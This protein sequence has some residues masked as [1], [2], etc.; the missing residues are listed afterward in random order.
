MGFPAGQVK[1]E[2]LGQVLNA[3]AVRCNVELL[4]EEG[5]KKHYDTLRT[6]LVGWSEFCSREPEL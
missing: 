3:L 5:G 6:E 4:K 2:D 1:K